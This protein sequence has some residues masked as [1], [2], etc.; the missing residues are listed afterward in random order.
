MT[1]NVIRLRPLDAD[2]DAR[3]RPWHSVLLKLTLTIF[4][5]LQLGVSGTS[6]RERNGAKTT[7]LKSSTMPARSVGLH[8]LS[9]TGP[10]SRVG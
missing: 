6:G 4:G 3:R 9:A 1:D 7:H 8:Q 10:I 5:T 2:D